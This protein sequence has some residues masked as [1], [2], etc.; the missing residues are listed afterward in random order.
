MPLAF[1]AFR[2]NRREFALLLLA[3]SAGFFLGSA[4]AVSELAPP[5]PNSLAWIPSGQ[6]IVVCVRGRLLHVPPPSVPSTEES[7]TSLV[8]ECTA[9][10]RQEEWIPCRGR[11]RIR[12]KGKPKGWGRGDR[13]EA[14]G[15]LQDLPKAGNP[16]QFDFGKHLAERDIVRIL[17][18][19]SWENLRRT[20]RGSPGPLR[21]LERLRNHA[22]QSLARALP[23]DDGALL[24]ALL[25]GDQSRLTS[26]SRT[27]FVRSGTV[28]LLAVSGLHLMLTVSGV[29]FLLRLLGL[30]GRSSAVVL[31][32]FVWLFAGLTGGRTPVLRAAT[33]STVYFGAELF[34]RE[35][36]GVNA[37]LLAAALLLLWRPGDLFA[38][39]F[40]LSFAAV[41]GILAFSRPLAERLLAEEVL[42]L[43]LSRFPDD[44]RRARIAY[45]VG[46]SVSVS[47]G[48]WIA[49]APLVLHHFH[50]L[51]PVTLLANLP[52]APLT[53]LLLAVGFL[54]LPGILLWP[55]V[56]PLALPA[57]LLARL[58]SESARFFSGLP[59]SHVFLPSPAPWRLVLGYACLFLVAWRPW[60]FRRFPRLPVLLPLGAAVLLLFLPAGEAVPEGLEM[61]VLEVG[62]GSCTVLRFPDGRVLLYDAGTRR[63]MDVGEW[64][65]APFLWSKGVRRIDL[66]V[67]SHS[68]T[69]H[70]SGIDSLL[71][72]LTVGRV[73]V[74]VGFSAKPEGQ[75]V[76]EAFRAR[77]VPVHPLHRE[78]TPPATWTPTLR[79]LGPPPRVGRGG[80]LSVNNA[81]LVLS[82]QYAGRKILLPGDLERLGLERLHDHVG[83]RTFD[84]LLAPHHGSDEAVGNELLARKRPSVVAVSCGWAFGA[85]ATETL[86]RSH[87]AKVFRT[88]RDGAVTI[89]IDENGDISAE[90][91]RRARRKKKGR[92]KVPR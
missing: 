73:L 20:E 29:Y 28:H 1:W 10:E 45:G 13:L 21:L 40:Q 69:D 87:G 2:R 18:T 84:I 38:P 3:G 60:R 23:G 41:I 42:V 24:S 59:G 17:S 7:V 75:R 90:A 31:I 58:L 11:L 8:L 49:T 85:T 67:L 63:G 44:R 6:P 76:L 16:G 92:G 46:L 71:E 77:G 27:A 50:I 72:R 56:L 65:V 33:M 82:V 62:Q 12:V 78:G 14:L 37:L 32:V 54:S 36:D 64:V 39:G 55:H 51:T 80:D 53:G 83:D 9:I 47:A 48:A 35:R 34:H 91:Y 88:C 5:P 89:L 61:T 4:R 68:D 43:R 79:I 25:L 19:P 52:A 86:Y 26:A 22:S 66:L 57:G 70:V 15:L 30:R 81:S 74:P